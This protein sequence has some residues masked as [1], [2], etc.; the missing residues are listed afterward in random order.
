VDNLYCIWYRHY[1][2]LDRCNNFKGLK[3]ERRVTPRV[4]VWVL[5]HCNAV[6]R[7]ATVAAAVVSIEFRAQLLLVDS[8][9]PTFFYFISCSAFVSDSSRA[10]A[11]GFVDNIPVNAAAIKT[12]AITNVLFIRKQLN[13]YVTI[14]H[15]H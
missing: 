7:L 5:V 9:L 1:V 3:K 8:P 6:T 15:I 13:L 11:I 10:N 12:E 14:Y 2:F 4:V